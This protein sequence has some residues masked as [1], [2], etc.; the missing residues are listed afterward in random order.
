MDITR[1][2]GRELRRERIQRGLTQETLADRAGLHRTYVSLIERGLR[3][4]TV[5]I[6][7]RLAKALGTEPARLVRRLEES[8]QA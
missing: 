1:A 8:A 4:P 5:E 7:F 2:L 3:M 6:L